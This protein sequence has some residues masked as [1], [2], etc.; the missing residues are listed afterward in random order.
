MTLQHALERVYRHPLGPGVLSIVNPPWAPAGVIWS[1]LLEDAEV[2][3]IGERASG[4]LLLDPV[5]GGVIWS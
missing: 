4:R 5:S 1:T 3:E 2:L